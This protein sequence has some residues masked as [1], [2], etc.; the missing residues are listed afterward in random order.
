MHLVKEYEKKNKHIP[1][2]E[3]TSNVLNRPTEI[4]T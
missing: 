3:L 1:A 4:L 2:A